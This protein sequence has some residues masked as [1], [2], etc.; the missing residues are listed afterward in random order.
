MPKVRCSKH[1]VKDCSSTFGAA[2]PLA[3]APAPP[4]RS[5]STAKFKVPTRVYAVNKEDVDKDADVVEGMFLVSG[6]L[7][8]VVDPGSTY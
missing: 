7:V 6:K 5:G 1:H 3:I 4:E 8:K 2:K